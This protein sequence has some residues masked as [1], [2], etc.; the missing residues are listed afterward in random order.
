MSSTTVFELLGLAGISIGVLAYVPQ[1]IHLA[2]KHCSAGVSARAWAMWLTS[3]SLIGA[4]ALHRQDPV[5]IALQASSL[6]SAAV[7]VF[8]TKRYRGMTCDAHVHLG[9]NDGAGRGRADHRDGA[10]AAAT[11]L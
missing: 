10:T 8:L 6:A 2:R 7:I 4:L 11:R 3:S 9:P 1:V 5:F